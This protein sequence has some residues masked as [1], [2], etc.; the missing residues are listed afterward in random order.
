LAYC[1]PFPEDKKKAVEWFRK[2][3]EQGN[4]DAQLDLSAC[5]FKGEG[6]HEDS[7]EAVTWLR[8]AAEQGHV[9]AQAN[10]GRCY[11]HGIAHCCGSSLGTM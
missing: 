6:V 7:A 8:K 2:A 3:A 10:L 1:A 11:Y 4:S 5:Y 9:E